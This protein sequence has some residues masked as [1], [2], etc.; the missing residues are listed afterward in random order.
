MINLLITIFTLYFVFLSDI[1]ITVTN[2]KIK[3]TIKYNGIVWVA[4]DYLT[5]SIW[6]SVDEPIKILSIKKEKI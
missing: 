3:R 2:N 6:F 4:L 5:R 1:T